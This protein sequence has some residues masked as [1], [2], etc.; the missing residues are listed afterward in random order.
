MYLRVCLYIYTWL[1]LIPPTPG[2]VFT[3]SARADVPRQS[4]PGRSSQ[5]LQNYYHNI[6]SDPFYCEAPL[7][8]I[9]SSRGADKRDGGLSALWGATYLQ[10]FKSASMCFFSL[11]SVCSFIA[12][13]RII[14]PGVKLVRPSRCRRVVGSWRR[15]TEAYQTTFHALGRDRRDIWW[16]MQQTRNTVMWCIAMPRRQPHACC[17]HLTAQLFRSSLC[18]VR[19]WE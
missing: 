6:S 13:Y 16:V 11:L 18:D 19:D 9:F 8:A 17:L 7:P 14:W 3:V 10:V 12:S 2:D 15:C 5:P 4:L 1:R